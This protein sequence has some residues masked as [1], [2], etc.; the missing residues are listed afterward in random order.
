M[1]ALMA[2]IL[3]GHVRA[4]YSSPQNQFDSMSFNFVPLVGTYRPS[5]SISLIGALFFFLVFVSASAHA[6]T[7]GLS[8]IVTPDV[9]PVGDLSLS[10]QWQAKEIANPYQF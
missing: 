3:E 8:Q 10:F 5:R 7:K 6:T 2:E 1:N 4:V 9:Q